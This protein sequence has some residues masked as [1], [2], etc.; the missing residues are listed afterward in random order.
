M[1]DTPTHWPDGLLADLDRDSAT[2]LYLQVSRGIEQAIRSGVIPG[3]ARLENE[4]AIGQLL[5]LSRPTV[6]RAIGELVD[7]GLLVRRRGVGTQVVN[8]QVT[9]PVAL[10]SLYEDLESASHRP[11]TQVLALAV[12]P[13]DDEVAGRLGI[14][15]GS[16][17]LSVRRRRTTDGVAVAVLQNWLPP[18]LTDITAEQLEQHGL[19]QVLRARG[20]TL[21]IATQ[22]I[23]ARRAERDEGALLGIP[24]TGPVLTMER[25]AYDDAGRAVEFGHHCYRPDL[26]SFET[27]LVAR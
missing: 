13:A 2:P 9:R 7:K 19:Y 22:R 25:V 23:G 21:K 6:R 4:I 27:T 24:R 5:R 3:G 12:V 11:G 15:A 26:Y 20:I 10:T 8:G 14:P 1:A 18:D 17:V 16:S